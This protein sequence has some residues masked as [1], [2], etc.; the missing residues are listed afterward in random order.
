MDITFLIGKIILGGYWLIFAPALFLP[1]GTV[2]L[3]PKVLRGI[4][5][6]VVPLLAIAFATLGVIFLLTLTLR[7][8]VTALAGVLAI[9]CLAAAIAFVARN[10]KQRGS[11]SQ[12][13]CIA[14]L[15]ITR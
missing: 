9:W 5:G 3:S 10:R 11:Q 12:E 15:S 4:C 6:Y 14:R 2:L 7:D 13:L 1:L 8:A